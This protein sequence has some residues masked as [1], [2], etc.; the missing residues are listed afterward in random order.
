MT[1]STSVQKTSRFRADS[2][3]L[4]PKNAHADTLGTMVQFKMTLS[5]RF[6]LHLLCHIVR[7]PAREYEVGEIQ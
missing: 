4:W 6:T 1:I 5:Q 3:K 2:R 7:E